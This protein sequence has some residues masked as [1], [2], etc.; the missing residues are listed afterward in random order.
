MKWLSPRLFALG[1]ALGALGTTAVLATNASARVKPHAAAA[2]GQP[3]IDWKR[4]V[5]RWVFEK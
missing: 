2:S 5:D 1:F 4:D 3:V